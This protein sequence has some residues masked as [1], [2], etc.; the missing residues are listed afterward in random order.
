MIIKSC[1]FHEMSNV[2]F[3]NVSNNENNLSVFEGIS[4]LNMIQK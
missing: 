3:L 4:Q 1:R 2:F